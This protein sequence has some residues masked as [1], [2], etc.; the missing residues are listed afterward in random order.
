MKL[1]SEKGFTGVDI[2]VA[3]I[4]ILLFMSLISILFFN[5]TK[6]SKSIDRKSEATYIATTLIESFKAKDYDDVIV[7]NG[8]TK[9]ENTKDEIGNSIVSYKI[10]NENIEITNSIQIKNG[11]T[12]T[13]NIYTYVPESQSSQEEHNDLV[14]VITVK[15]EYKIGNEKKEVELTTSIVR[16]F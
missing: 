13:T 16:E 14:K 4:V 11:Y 10:N 9:I 8:Y 2:T 3:I 15:V 1:K 5:I 12:C 7:T 6:S